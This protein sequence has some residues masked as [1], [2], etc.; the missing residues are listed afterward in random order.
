MGINEVSIP[1]ER[2][3]ISI[4]S[5]SRYME[6]LKEKSLFLLSPFYCSFMLIMFGDFFHH[7]LLFSSHVALGFLRVGFTYQIP[8]LLAIRTP[9][10]ILLW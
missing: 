10:G 3:T 2:D 9:G 6:E 8:F 5:L 1:V 4:L 7:L